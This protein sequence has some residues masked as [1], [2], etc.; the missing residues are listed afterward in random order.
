MSPHRSTGLPARSRP[1]VPFAAVGA[2][3]VVAGGLVAAATAPAPSEHGSWAAAY[4]VLVAGVTQV[5]LGVGQALLAPRPPSRRVVTGEITA[6]NAGNVAVLAGT[7][8][9]VA[10]L[11]DA[12]GAL[13]VVALALLTLG[14]RHQGGRR[15]WGLRLYRL[16]IA[17]VLVSIPIGLLLARAG[18][19]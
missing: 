14:V 15:G 18:H 4:L 6:W 8:L 3:C 19:S 10:P 2:A 1:A 17:V 5:A 12:G 7:L 11:V 9:G 13:L 16:L